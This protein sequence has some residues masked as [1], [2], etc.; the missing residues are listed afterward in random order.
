MDGRALDGPGLSPELG[1]LANCCRRC[2]LGIR[3]PDELP[4]RANVD[5]H[6]VLAL[7]RF[8]RV[9][10]LVFHSLNLV[11][12]IV[13]EEVLTAL[14]S[15]ASTIAATNLQVAAECRGLREEFRAA[16]ISMLFLKGLTLGA[17]AYGNPSLK[18]AVDV[19]LLIDPA[20]LAAAAKLLLDRGYRLAI[21]NAPAEEASL[22]RW[23]S[24]SKESV[25]TKDRPALQIDLHTRTADNPTLVPN[26][27]VHSP[28]QTVDVGSGIQL[29]TFAQEELFAYLAVHGASSAWFR[30]K[31]IADFAALVQGSEASELEH[32]YRRSQ[33]LGA[34]RAA[35]QALLLADALF[36]T[37]ENAPVLRGELQ[38]DPATQRLFRAAL[39]LLI[40]E[41]GEPTERLLGTLPIHW[42]QFLLLPGLAFKLG[43]FSR[44]A[45]AILQGRS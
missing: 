34:G 38:S 19:D 4:E 2:F 13:P 14:G 40:G 45:G 31:W 44:Q 11:H 41:R 22:Q 16:R 5:W 12:S 37:L 21:P 30:V 26:I 32:L 28:S 18:A 33:Q 17:L 8:H 25:W 3:A 24:S 23:H 43:E 42:T 27:T 15:D 10:G 35:G 1:L 7:A 6:H 39:R 9:Q 29:P 36:G 20:D